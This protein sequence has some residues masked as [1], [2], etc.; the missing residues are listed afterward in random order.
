MVNYKRQFFFNSITSE[1][2]FIVLQI[3]FQAIKIKMARFQHKTFL[4][5]SQLQ[6]TFSSRFK[7]YFN[8]DR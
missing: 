8:C 6:F 7:A 2:N 5:R 4:K 1:A 3:T